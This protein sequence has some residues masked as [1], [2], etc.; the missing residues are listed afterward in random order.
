MK[1]TFGQNISVTLFGE[2]HGPAIGAV[3]DGLPAG[4]PV[5]GEYIAH[6]LSL[7][8]P[9][10]KMS[11]ARSE[12]D[13]YS[14]LSGV[15]RGFTCGTPICITIPNSDTRSSDYSYGKARPSHAD[16]AA[17]AKYGGYEDYRGGGHF[18]GRL[19]AALVAAGALL[20]YA[21][22]RKNIQICTHISEIYGITDRGFND[23]DSDTAALEN[24]YFAVLD[25]AAGQ[26][27]KEAIL[28]ARSDGDSVGGILETVV[29]GVPAGVGEPWFDTFE[30]VL[31]HALFSVPAV[32]GVEFGGGF[33]L[34]KLRGSKANDPLRIKNGKI[35]AEQNLSGGINGGIANGMPV[36]F[37]TVIKPTPTIGKEQ[38][39]I[40]FL[41]MENTVIASAGRHDPCI[42]QRARAVVDAVSAMAVCDL[43]TARFGTEY[44]K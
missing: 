5:D 20:Q 34:A 28:A 6:K 38:N 10:D 41:K 26:K 25:K 29:F 35:V 4:I 18:S 36:L 21:L 9:Q 3:I 31:S 22:K 43:I 44:L 16:L 15:F 42:V 7:R 14:I 24:E 2:S 30:G 11:T 37:K 19:T 1:N 8:R 27:M 39:T 23:L 32:K 13:N 17:F 12:K 33:G 40:D